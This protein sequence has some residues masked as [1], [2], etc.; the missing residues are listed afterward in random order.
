MRYFILTLVLL[1]FSISFVHSQ[2]LKE[3]CDEMLKATNF[4]VPN[5]V[6]FDLLGLS[7]GI[8]HRPGLTRDFKLDWVMQ[9][10]GINPNL[11]IEIQPVWLLYNKHK[12]YQQF[13]EA[14][15][16]EKLF[17]SLNLSVGTVSR[18]SFQSLAYGIKLNLYTAKDPV[19]DEKL[20]DA[21][22]P[23]F[24]ESEKELFMLMMDLD[25]SEDPESRDSL[26]DL[27][28]S[29]RQ[30]V[31]EDSLTFIQQSRQALDRFKKESWN[32]SIID[33]G[34]GQ[35]FHYEMTGP[36]SLRIQ[37]SGLAVWIA[38]VTG[39]GKHTLLNAMVKY[40]KFE[41]NDILEYG[42]NLRYGG[43]SANAFAEISVTNYLSDLKP[44]INLAYG[45][46]YKMKNNMVIQGSIKTRYD[47]GFALREL[48]PSINI[49]YQM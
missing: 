45:I 26:Q 48:L 44:D 23:R 27:I 41:E 42:A 32:S 14:G 35:T 5:S 16:L 30:K 28:S 31:A 20:I 12:N 22:T 13:K 33:L 8:I 47:T 24:Q 40:A 36:D 11:A 43:E 37:N 18:D 9:D 10:G 21:L 1:L 3:Q 2:E 4:T 25:N 34:F 19:F 15:Y 6:A 39:I 38:G 49:N 17:S 29:L 7:P 46:E